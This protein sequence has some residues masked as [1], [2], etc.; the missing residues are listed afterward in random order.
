IK[1]AMIEIDKLLK[2]RKTRMILQIHDELLFEIAEGEEGLKED[3]KNIM[4][5]VV[6]L[7]VPLVVDA[8]IGKNWAE[9]H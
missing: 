2:D 9:A 6:E 1:K 5:H 4:E 7:D 8:N 3:I